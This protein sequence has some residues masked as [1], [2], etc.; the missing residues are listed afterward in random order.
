[1]KCKQEELSR[2]ELSQVIGGQKSMVL[3]ALPHTM[4]PDG[5]LESGRGGGAQVRAISSIH[6]WC[7]NWWK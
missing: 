1:M 3:V 7:P 5:I 6:A 2:K 4:G